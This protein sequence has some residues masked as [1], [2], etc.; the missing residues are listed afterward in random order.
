LHR[1]RSTPAT[2]SKLSLG[3]TALVVSPQE[4]EPSFYLL[5]LNRSRSDALHG[6]FSGLARGQVKSHARSGMQKNMKEIKLSIE[7]LYRRN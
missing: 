4:E 1:N 2:I 7:S 5:Y 6:G 3:L